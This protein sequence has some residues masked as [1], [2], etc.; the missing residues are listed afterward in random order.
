[1]KDKVTAFFDK[2]LDD[3][4]S[5]WLRAKDNLVAAI[6][7][8]GFPDELGVQIAKHLGSPKAI[9]RMTGYLLNE[10]PKNVE[11]I[12]DEM[13][14]ICSEIESWKSKK[15]AEEANAKWNEIHYRG[16]DEDE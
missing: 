14:A 15:A 1:M 7:Q 2:E 5:R 6:G 12:V 13:L 3:N 16:F 11:I 9:Y 8:L 4:K 10:R